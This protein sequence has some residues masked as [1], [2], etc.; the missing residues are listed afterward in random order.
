MA[1]I[2]TVLFSELIFNP[3]TMLGDQMSDQVNGGIGLKEPLKSTLTHDFQVAKWNPSVLGGMPTI[4]ATSGDIMYPLAMAVSFVTPM[5]KS[6]GITMIL[7]VFLAGLFFYIMLRK[8][9]GFTKF[10]AFIG[11]LFY[12]LNPMFFSHVSPGHDGKMY[13]IAWLPFVIWQL[14][15]LL[16]N[17]TFGKVLLVAFGVGM[18]PLTPHVQMTYFAMWGFGAY[19]LFYTIRQIVFLK[20]PKQAA[21]ASVAFWLAIFLGCGFGAVQL[22]PA[23]SYVQDAWSVRGT[24]KDISF[25]A[26]WSLHWAEAISL[27]IPDFGNAL[28]DYWGDNAFKLNTEYAGAMAMLGA[29]LSVIVKPSG[30]RFF[31]IATAAIAFLFSMGTHTPVLQFAYNFIPGVNKFRAISMIMF[32]WAF[33]SVLLSI[34]FMK[35]LEKEFWK[36]L[37]PKAAKNWAIGLIS[38]AVTITIV[39]IISSN[40]GTFVPFLLDNS[41]FFSQKMSA[42]EANFSKNF[43]PALWGWWGMT[44][45]ILVML[46]FAIKGKV[47]GKA[48][49]IAMLIFGLIDV[50]R[51]NTKFIA[52]TPSGSITRIPDA[53][54]QLKLTQKE[55]PF[56]VHFTEGA[57]QQ[58]RNF[59]GVYKLEGINGFHDNELKWYRSFRGD[60]PTAQHEVRPGWYG[61]GANFDVFH[62]VQDSTGQRMLNLGSFQMGN[63]YLNAANCE[64]I[65]AMNDGIMVAIKNQN[66][67]PRIAFTQSYQV[68]DTITKIDTLGA[69]ATGKV[70]VLK[71]GVGE[72]MNEILYT[73]T[74]NSR[75][76]VLLET[77]PSFASNDSSIIDPVIPVRWKKYKTNHRIAEVDV[78]AQ[79]LLRIAEVWY[80]GWVVLLDGKKVSPLRSDITWMA[81]EVS[82][83]KHTLEM[84]PLSL[85][86]QTA[87][88]ISVPIWLLMLVY[89]I[90]SL[91]RRKK[92]VV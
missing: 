19:W 73:S 68:V 39:A 52:I 24:E 63:P 75:K 84:K 61:R 28:Q 67:L 72:R 82:P 15:L 23:F 12:M 81:L 45:T 41:E 27:W 62:T 25:V 69:D 66:A 53:I 51:V 21:I 33:A 38:A 9:F 91:F 14:K 30:W 34:F 54:R 83:G 1:L 58:L 55:H 37:S 5:H 20:Q 13:V 85:Y 86:L 47:A 42:Y 40:S 59:A 60:D 32:W 4:D 7:H 10:L 70:A 90:V 22:Y 87:Q 11:G 31:W 57:D 88:K 3:Y 16:E 8:G 50:I 78:P 56:R 77:K 26:S 79:G 49:V 92:A 65:L 76:T 71:T 36:N 35:D 48:I 80:P 46:Y 64:Y 74:F 2:V 43:V 18:M 6:F 17:P 44:I 89:G 29:I